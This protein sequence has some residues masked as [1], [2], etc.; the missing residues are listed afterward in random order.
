MNTPGLLKCAGAVAVL[1]IVSA[2]GNGSTVAPAT[3]DANSG[4]IGTSAVAAPGAH[5]TLHAVPGYPAIVPEAKKK[6]KYYEYIINDY[7]TYA[8]IFDYPKG[9]TQVGQI[10]DVGGQGCTNLL[11]GYGKK[12]VW[13]VAAPNNIALYAIP[14]KKL[15]MLS[16][17]VG[18]PSS[19]G[20]DANG[21]LAVGI[22]DGSGG[23][24]VIVYKNATGSGTVYTT[25]LA[26]EYFDGYD[27]KGN[28]FADGFT[29]GSSFE[30]I[31]LA[32]GSSKFVTVTTSN[33]VHF[34][35]SVQWD[36]KYLDV[37]DQTANA[38]YQY[39]VS[40]TMATLKGTI[41]FSGS[42]D[43]AQTWIATGLVYCADAGNNNGSVFKYP[44]GGSPIATFSG[45]F[46]Q[47]L[48]T[49]AATK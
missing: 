30:L 26:R 39:T 35:G 27:P 28:L 10:N 23:G 33:T 4:Y 15:R 31:E 49:V 22:L 12:T 18:N 48:G 17:S 42:S 6:S 11:Y 19:C 2:C 47:P 13:I 1:A 37:T 16:D 7:Y 41:Q 14:Q 3:G 36:G 46:D 21:D 45:N 29:G 9:T 24:D 38:M 32:K 43:C 25:S 20:M 8:S 44:A 5:P 34:P 40:G